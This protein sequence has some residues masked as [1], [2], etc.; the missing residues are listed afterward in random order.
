LG[1][2]QAKHVD[3]IVEVMEEFAQD[4]ARYFLTNSHISVMGKK[5]GL[6]LTEKE[7]EEIVAYKFKAFG[8]G[9]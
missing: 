5:K 7:I 8:N 3:D 9:S 1:E 6:L 2:L 4:F